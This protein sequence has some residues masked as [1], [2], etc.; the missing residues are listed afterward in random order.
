MEDLRYWVAFNRIPSIGRAKFVLMEQ[1]FGSLEAAWHA[2]ASELKEAGLDQRALQAIKTRRASIDP[3]AELER[4]T[5]QSIKV[6]TWRDSSYPPLLKEIYDLPPVLYVIGSLLPEDERS[7]AVVGTRKATAYGREVAYRLSSDLAHSGVTVVSGLARGIDGIA[8]RAALEA[9]G[10]TIA[11]LASG[12]DTIYPREHSQLAQQIVKHG[13]LVSEHPLGVRPE[14]QNFPRRNRIMSGMTLGTLVIEAGEI[15]GALW[16][17]RHALEQDREVFAVPGSIFSP[18]SRSTNQLI[19]EGA[20]LVTD[21]KDI[22]EELNLSVVGQQVE[23]KELFPKD[24]TESQVLRYITYEPVHIDEVIRRSD[25]AI[26]TV[27]STLAMLEVKGLVRQVGAM[28]Y[29]RLKET[30]AEYE[31]VV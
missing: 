23:M 14:A 2:P 10:R 5:S 15:S 20:K 13:A 8:H 9:G 3:D 21:Y 17:V 25:L 24:D 16:T 31:P 27:S 11:V 29:V 30:V 4:L 22:L 19:Q 28:N 26:T 18:A 1:H 12:L 7:V 6:V